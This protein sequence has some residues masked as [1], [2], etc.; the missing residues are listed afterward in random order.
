MLDDIERINKPNGVHFTS[1]I[2]SVLMTFFYEIFKNVSDPSVITPKR[3]LLEV[4]PFSYLPKDIFKDA[5]VEYTFLLQGEDREPSKLLL[6]YFEKID[7]AFNQL[8]K[9]GKKDICKDI[10]EKMEEAYNKTSWSFFLDRSFV[11]LT[12]D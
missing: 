11:Y 4:F 12:I 3:I 10:Q 9:L 8:Y 1:E 6:K 5:I 2:L 7:L